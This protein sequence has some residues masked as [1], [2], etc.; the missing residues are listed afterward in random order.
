MKRSYVILYFHSDGAAPSKVFK[1][2]EGLGFRLSVGPFD[3]LYEW[4]HAP[5]NDEIIAMMDALY[6]SLT[7]L[8]VNFKFY[9]VD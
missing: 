7:G 3:L 8:N 6:K 2:V 5:S 9:T 4:D 1:R